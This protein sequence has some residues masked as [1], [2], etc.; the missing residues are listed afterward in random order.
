MEPAPS[1][2]LARFVN[3]GLR[4]A[5]L[6]LKLALSLYMARWLALRDFG[7]YG[8]VAGAVAILI[9]VL[10]VRLDYVVAREIVGETAFSCAKTMRDQLAFYGLNYL[11]LAVIIFVLAIT[12][13]LETPSRILITIL[14][15]S[16][17][18]SLAAISFNNMISL[19]HPI[20]ANLM[21]LLRSGLWVVPAV[22][23]G[24]GSETFRS[25][26]VIFTAWALGAAASIGLA[27]W[28]WRS[29][30][31]KTLH[32]VAIDWQWIRKGARHSSLIWLST[33]AMTAGTFV[34]RFVAAGRL[35]LELAGV[36]TFYTLFASAL[37]SLVES[38]VFFAYPRLVALHQQDDRL[39]FAREAWRLV[40]TACAL[41]AGIG[42]VFAIVVP[43][44]A[45]FTGRQPLIDHASTLWLLLLGTW[46]RIIAQALWLIL[47][48]IH[49]DRAIWIGDI[50]YI[51]PALGSNMV[52]VPICGLIGI[53]YS[54]VF[55]ALLILFWRAWH[56]RSFYQT[57]LVASAGAEAA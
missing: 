28:Q 48:S 53:G 46:I 47:F 56:V 39:R 17:L 43:M 19:A 30:P 36:V 51:I 5:S 3:L 34:D 1:D 26:N 7:E 37:Y 27:G 15:L 38:S 22:L 10:G 20:V 4:L 31:W 21:F 16:I 24:I 33:I 29:L 49:N 54:S 57:Q 8:L 44:I 13:L 32:K 35:S 12:G 41:S 9:T 25:A 11:S 40:G 14:V 45:V 2:K 55:S 18:E 6:S 52:L 23:L 50:L 42:L